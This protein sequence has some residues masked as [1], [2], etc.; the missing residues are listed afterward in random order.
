MQLPRRHVQP[1]THA[2]VHVHAEHLE[3]LAAVAPT[4]AARRT[5]AAIDIRFHRAAVAR[6]HGRDIV[7]HLGDLDR[8]LVS[9][10]A[11]IREERLAAPPRVVVGAAHADA[12]HAHERHAGGGRAR[13]I[14][15]SRTENAG[16]LEN[17][18]LHRT[19]P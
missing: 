13:G 12:A 15:R 3:L 2:A 1:L 6:P 16:L 14:G 5:R 10:N 11:W 18:G 7:G 19:R 4:A 9:E 17:D 8:E